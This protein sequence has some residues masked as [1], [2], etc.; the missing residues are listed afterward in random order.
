M[1]KR[2]ATFCAPPFATSFLRRELT[3]PRERNKEP[4]VA[5]VARVVSLTWNVNAERTKGNVEALKLK[6]TV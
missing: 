5:M 6:T 3:T 2:D 4:L 1:A